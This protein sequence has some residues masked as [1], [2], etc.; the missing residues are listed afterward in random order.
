VA[1]RGQWRDAE[2]RAATGTV[3]TVTIYLVRHAKALRRSTW[4]DDDALRPLSDDGRW[5]ADQLVGRLAALA[6]GRI[7]SSPARRCVETLRPLATRLGRD[8]ETDLRL[9]EDRGAAGA[10]ALLE[11]LPDGSV[12]SSHGDVIPSVVR[13]LARG[14]LEM[15]G[16]PDWRKASVWA[17]E[18]TRGAWTAG[19]AWAPPRPEGSAGAD[20]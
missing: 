12:V 5:Q 19:E 18:R 14:G 10:I 8:V 16:K 4:E 6:T 11:E 20:D 15:R 9:Y 7:V 3:A 17:L 2:R 13:A 1:R